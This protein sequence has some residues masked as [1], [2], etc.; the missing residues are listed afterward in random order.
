MALTDEQKIRHARENHKEALL[1]F[2]S[3]TQV[4]SYFSGEPQVVKTATIA[5]LQ[6]QIDQVDGQI[7]KLV[8]LKDDL[9][10]L[11]TELST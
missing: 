5:A 3:W 10:D 8:I 9:E 2:S 4:K 1:N 6:E 11:K 7:A